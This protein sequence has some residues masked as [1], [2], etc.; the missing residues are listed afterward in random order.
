MEGKQN[1]EYILVRSHARTLVQT[2]LTTYTTLQ[3]TFERGLH[4][5]STSVRS[6]AY[7]FHR[8]Q[9]NRI[10]IKL[11]ELIANAKTNI[12]FNFPYFALT[13]Q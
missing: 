12:W 2:Y 9:I 8:L 4:V 1:L 7:K 10:G 5:L 13:Y 11:N 3:R 6:D